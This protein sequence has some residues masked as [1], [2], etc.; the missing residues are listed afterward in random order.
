MT[1]VETELW[2]LRGGLALALSLNISRPEAD[3]VISLVKD[4]KILVDCS[5]MKYFPNK[6]KQWRK[7]EPHL[8]IYLYFPKT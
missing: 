8:I 6:N 1:N 3:I 2:A 5:F 4:S 7:D